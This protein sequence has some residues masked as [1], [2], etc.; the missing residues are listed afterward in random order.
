MTSYDVTFGYSGDFAAE[1]HGLIPADMQ[2]DTV[3]DD[4]NNSI[5]AALGTC[6]F[7]SFPFQCVGITWHAVSAPAGSEYLRISLFDDYTDG[8]DDLDLY[9][10]NSSFGFVG[11]SGTATSA[12]EVNVTSP[13]DTLYFVAVHGWQTDGPD[14]NYTLFSWAL[15]AAD[16]G[17]MTLTAPASATLGATDTVDV[18]WSGLS[19]DN[20]YLG[21]V[22]YH[23]VAAPAGYN[24]G[25]V[26]F[27]IIRIDT[28]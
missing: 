18:D 5:N 22:T 26:D 15:G 7:S 28:D 6:D 17:N 10:W 23:D 25:L 14:A 8:Q 24:D 4:P 27:T 1:T 21:S 20:K 2:A 13:G 3:D 19:A 12:E 11:S 9:V 16:A